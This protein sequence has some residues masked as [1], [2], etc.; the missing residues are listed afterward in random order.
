MAAS[1]C[2]HSLKKKVP[3]ELS[4]TLINL[5]K[6]NTYL[7]KTLAEMSR[8]HSEH[9]KLVERFLSLET[10]RLESCHQPVAKDER[11]TLS[12]EVLCP[13][14]GSVSKLVSM[15]REPSTSSYTRSEDV[16]ATEWSSRVLLSVFSSQSFPWH[17]SLSVRLLSCAS[18]SFAQS[19]K[20]LEKNKQ[21][22]EYDQQ[23]EAYVRAVV[24]RILE[25]EKQ[26][27][28]ANQARSQQHN[29]DHSDGE[30]E[31]QWAA[32]THHWGNRLSQQGFFKLSRLYERRSHYE[33]LLQKAKE[34]QEVLREQFE[35]THRSLIIAQNWCRERETEVEQLRQ[36]LQSDSL[37]RESVQGEHRESEEEEQSL[38]EEGKELEVRLKEEKRRSANFELQ[39][40]L[41]QRY[42]LNRHHVDQEKIA[43]LTRQIKISSQDLEDEKQNCSYLKKQM[44]KILKMLPKAKGHVT[45][46]SKKNQQDQCSSE[47]VQAP[48]PS[49]ASSAHSSGL[50]ESFLE[51]PS[52][53]AEYPA[54]HYRELLHHL[55]GCQD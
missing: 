45:K 37:S 34:E 53:Q 9:N 47:E 25:L 33:N 17:S 36:Q 26:L 29:D 7:K 46:Q 18:Y 48:S 4:V 41:F 42:M 12:S 2:K 54:T 32:D 6:E 19:L 27:R 35:V 10:I 31:G 49:L 20:A 23:R 40:N 44:V 39:A 22:L 13:K 1:K 16:Y 28:E 52:C 8:H 43:D 38:E 24:D 11:A 5:R 14:E 3:S 21:W 15:R 30:P 50:N 51:C 55:E